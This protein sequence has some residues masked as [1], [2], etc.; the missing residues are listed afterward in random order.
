MLTVEKH[1][2]AVFMNE[3]IKL[4]KYLL[5]YSELRQDIIKT[6][7]MNFEIQK[8]C[9]KTEKCLKSVIKLITQR[10]FQVP[11]IKDNSCIEWEVY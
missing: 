10:N 11:E 1:N 3:R 4:K 2:S 9:Y 5:I 7:N 6:H 8:K